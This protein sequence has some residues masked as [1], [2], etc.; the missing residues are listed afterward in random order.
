M[1]G[2]I[3]SPAHNCLC[4][5]TRLPVLLLPA[6]RNG[7]WSFHV[8]LINYSSL[9]YTIFTT[10]VVGNVRGVTQLDDIL[11]VVCAKS[12]IIKMFTADTLSP[13]GEGIHVEGMRDPTDIVACHHDRQLY[14]GD[15]DCIWRVSLSFGHH[16]CVKWLTGLDVNR[17]SLTLHRLL[18][19][20]EWPPRLRQYSTTDG[21]LVR[22]VPL[23]SYVKEVYNAAET[24]RGTFVLCHQGTSE[25]EDQYAVSELFTLCHSYI[26]ITPVM[27]QHKD[28]A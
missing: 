1:S 19:T 5:G 15:C 4:F 2:A 3:Y 27:K 10:H 17:L 23:P 18:V 8:V 11:N 13:L 6:N 20:S 22:E 28:H 21:Q 25:D 12:S 16:S 9:G 14:V 7:S 26:K 24:T